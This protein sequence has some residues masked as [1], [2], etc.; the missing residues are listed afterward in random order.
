MVFNLLDND[1]ATGGNGHNNHWTDFSVSDGDHIDISKLLTDWSGKSEDLGQYLSIEHT[2]SGDT[3]VSIDRD[4]A[5][6]QYQSTQLITL[7]GVQPT[8]EELLHHDSSANHG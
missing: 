8:L 6:T 7:D 2:A 5:G 1:D 4:G 3:V